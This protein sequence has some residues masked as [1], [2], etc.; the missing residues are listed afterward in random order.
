MF[1]TDE[2]NNTISIIYWHAWYLVWSLRVKDSPLYRS[3]KE[4]RYASDLF[5]IL[6]LQFIHLKSLDWTMGKCCYSKTSITWA[7]MLN[8]YLNIQSTLDISNSDISNSAYMYMYLDKKYILTA[9]SNHNLALE[10]LLLDLV[11]YTRSVN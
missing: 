11:Q 10:I 2:E 1:S 3:L 7:W 5:L 9:F 8:D 6:N 4:T